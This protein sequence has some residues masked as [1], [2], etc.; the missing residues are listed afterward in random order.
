M[1]FGKKFAEGIP[2]QVMEN[3][4][5]RKAFLGTEALSC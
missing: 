2:E 1:N 5:V 3:K 4:E